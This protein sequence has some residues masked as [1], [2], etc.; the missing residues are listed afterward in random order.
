MTMPKRHEREKI[1][2]KAGAKIELALLELQDEHDLTDVEMLQMI[3]SWTQTKLKYM[4]RFERHG[5][6]EKPGGLA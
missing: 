4:L 3:N 5:H 6:Y 2:H 1:T